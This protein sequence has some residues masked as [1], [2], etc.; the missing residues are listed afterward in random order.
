MHTKRSASGHTIIRL[1]LCVVGA[2]M[3]AACSR[4]PNDA[5]AATPAALAQLG[6][7][8][9]ARPADDVL[10]ERLTPLQYKVTQRSGTERPYRNEYWDNKESGLYVDIVSGEPL[11]SSEDKYDSRTGWPSFTRPVEPGRIVQHSDRTLGM[12]RI[13]VRSRDGDSHL[14]HLFNDG[15]APEGLRYC[16]NSASL[17]FIPVAQL[18]AEGYGEYLAL[19]P[20]AAPAA[21]LPQNNETALLAG[22]CF[23]GMQEILRQIPGVIATDVGY[24][25]GVVGSPSYDDVRSGK[26]GHA[27]TVRVS[28]DPSVLS[29]EDLLENWFFR[30][31]DPTT[32]NR[33]GNDIGTQYR[34]AIFTFTPEQRTTALAAIDRV[35]ASGKWQR[36]VVTEVADAGAYTMAEG[37]HQDYLQKNPNGYTCHFLRD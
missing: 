29:Y 4:L 11:F 24:S 27:E 25:G 32:K 9:Y 2:L 34:S 15:P 22:G 37:Y 6:N 14:G 35:D 16:I 8:E 5:R 28:F 21:T 36:D 3:I 23:W 13:E 1:T 10:R 12:S 31:H 26:S 17:R 18:E 19:F 30:M 7:G 20:G 33:Q